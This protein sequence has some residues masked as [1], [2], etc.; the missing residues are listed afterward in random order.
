M[1]SDRKSVVILTLVPCIFAFL[2]AFKIF[3]FVF[4]LQQFVYDTRSYVWFWYLSCSSLIFLD[5]CFCICR[6]FWTVL[7]LVFPPS[8]VFCPFSLFS[9]VTPIMLLLELN[10]QFFCLFSLFRAFGF[11][12]GNIYW[13][14]QVHSLFSSISSNDEPIKSALHLCYCGFVCVFKK[15]SISI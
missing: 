14:L 2:T 3:P 15:V 10:D 1:V 5:L 8:Y 6:L 13:I 12:L 11:N 9:P 7:S 4:G